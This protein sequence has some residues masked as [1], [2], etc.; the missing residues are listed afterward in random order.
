MGWIIEVVSN[1]FFERRI[2]GYIASGMT[3]SEAEWQ[4]TS[5]VNDTYLHG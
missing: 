1:W 5:D 2:R 3:R 4:V